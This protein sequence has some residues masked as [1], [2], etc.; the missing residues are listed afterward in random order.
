MIL[1]TG[2]TGNVG[3]RLVREL[4]AAGE[5]TRALVRSE[6]AAGSLGALGVEAVVGAFEDGASLREAV[7][8][9]DQVYLVSPPG[10]DG[11]VKQ[12]LA[13]LDAAR[14][15]GVTRIVKQSSIAADEPTEATIVVAHRRIEEAIEASGS[16]WTHLRPNWF[17]Q[18]ELGQAA[19][20]AG[21]GVFY[22]P[23]FTSVSMIDAA[24]VAAVAARVLTTEGHEGKAYVLTG[25]EALS[26]ADLAATYSRVLGRPVRWEEVTFEQARDS[27]REAG[28]PE[29]LAVGFPEVMQGYRQGG[30]TRRVSPA[31][32]ELTGRPP[33]AFEEF[34]REH[35]DAYSA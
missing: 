22:A 27:M 21:D 25:P 33:R 28:M 14:A 20:V 10:V 13:V 8:G 9:V 31:V 34:L 30:V 4:T 7:D 1:V 12:Q 29:D 6:D 32:E 3:T 24:D 16:S 17:M 35:G 11:M 18:N 19:S 26:Y 5:P 23:D 15:G 2:A